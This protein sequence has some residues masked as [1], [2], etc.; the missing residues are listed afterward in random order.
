MRVGSTSEEERAWVEAS[1]QL[2]LDELNIKD[3]EVIDDPTQLASVNIKPN[4][5]KLGPKLGK[6]MKVL[7]G[8]LRNLDPVSRSDTCLR[9][10]RYCGR[11]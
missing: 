11:I 6:Q 3:L 5:P 8:G 2:I 7:M 1:R 10:V 9:R 4:L